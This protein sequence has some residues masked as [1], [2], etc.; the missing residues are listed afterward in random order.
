MSF[1]F[2]SS[3]FRAFGNRNY[4]LFFTGQSISRMGMW[5]QRTA[6]IWVVYS[7][8]HSPFMLG[9]TLFAEQFP[10]FLFSALGGIVSDRYNRYRLIL[11]T[12]SLSMVQ[13]VIL[14]VVTYTGHDAVWVLLVLS[15]L[16]GTINAFDVP[17]R[18]PLV[19]EMVN[20]PEDLP[21]AL[22]LNSSLT[23]LAKM[24]GPAL[25]GIVLSEWGAGT[26]FLINAVSFI[27]II[28]CLLLMKLPPQPAPP[29]QQKVGKE[30]KDGFQYLYRT[31]EIG[32][33]LLMLTL[34]SLFVLPYRTLLPVFAKVVFEGDATTYG[35]IMGFIGLGAISGAFFLASLKEGSRLKRILAI[36]TVILGISLLLFSRIQ[37]LPVVLLFAV[38]IGFGAMAQTTVCNILVQTKSKPEMR[39]RAMSYQAMAAFG[40][41]PLGGLLIGAV[42][43]RIGAPVSLFVQGIIA[44]F[45][46]F[47]FSRF[48]WKKEEEEGASREEAAR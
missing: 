13:A 12:Q 18:Q 15:A 7:M 40:M 22:A 32:M 17:A 10:S 14:T 20:E 47:A 34:V 44:L 30:L 5:M 36:N 38:L 46:A 25:A 19:H 1:P 11:L 39:G 45:I 8:T 24:V 31:P 28:V 9:L 2:K 37:N 16:L 27:A 41:M 42:S 26:C 4:A 43:E 23:N 29:P 35:Y 6:V 33:P 21:N 3:T 48:S